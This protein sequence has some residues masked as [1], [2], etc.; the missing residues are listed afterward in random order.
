MKQK[1]Q[2][3]MINISYTALRLWDLKRTEEL[4]DMFAR[5]SEELDTEAIVE[6][7]AWDDQVNTSIEQTGKLPKEFGGLDMKGALTKQRVEV[8]L[9][10][11]LLLVTKPDVLKGSVIYEIKTGKFS[12]SDYANTMQVPIYLFS[13]PETKRGIILHYDQA[14]DKMDWFLLHKTDLLMKQTK[15]YI[16]QKG[17]EIKDF[18]ESQGI[19]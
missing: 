15:D 3:N 17:G 8:K 11:D 13:I 9:N 18:L 1:R 16:F 10:D 4:I 19:A 2:K 12:S 6:G 5:T 14:I 7:R